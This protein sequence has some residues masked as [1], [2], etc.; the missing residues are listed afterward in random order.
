MTETR[1]IEGR[2]SKKS[3]LGNKFVQDPRI[4]ATGLDLRLMSRKDHR[5]MESEGGLVPGVD[6]PDRSRQLI[7]KDLL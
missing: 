4:L 6:T 2:S 7:C 1:S 5:R 3:Q